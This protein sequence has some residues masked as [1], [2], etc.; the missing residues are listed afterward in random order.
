ME[1]DVEKVEENEDNCPKRQDL[2]T[3]PPTTYTTTTTHGRL[4][5]LCTLHTHT[6]Y[7]YRTICLTGVSEYWV[8]GIESISHT[9]SNKPAHVQKAINPDI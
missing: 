5:I 7:Y 9:N 8:N 4:Q 3:T 6:Q 2:K 1:A